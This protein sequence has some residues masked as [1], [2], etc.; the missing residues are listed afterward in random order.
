MSGANFLNYVIFNSLL[1]FVF[2]SAIALWRKPSLWLYLFTLFLGFIVGWLDLKT[3]EVSSS[4]LMLLTFGFFAGFAQP[5]RAWLWGLFLGIWVPVLSFI[6]ANLRVTSPT[7]TELVTSFL[8]LVFS[9]AGAFAGA[10]V[11][12]FAAREAIDLPTE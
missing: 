10:V 12:R 9:L 6:A 8:A 3:T 1:L 5:R 2:L 4:V 7:S 11:R